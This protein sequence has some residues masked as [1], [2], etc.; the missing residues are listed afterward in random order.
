MCNGKFSGDCR[1][2]RR[3]GA[4]S[5]NV[6]NRQKVSKHFRHFSTIC[7]RPHISGPFWGALKFYNFHNLVNISDIFYCFGSGATGRERRAGGRQ[8]GFLLKVDGG[9]VSIRPKSI[10]CLAGRFGYFSFFFCSEKGKGESGSTR[11]GGS[12]FCWKSGGGGVV[13]QELRSCW[14]ARD[15]L[16]AFGPKS[17]K[18]GWK[19]GFSPH[20]GTG[21]KMAEKWE[22]SPE[23]RW[24]MA[25]WGHLCHFSAIFGGGGLN[26]FFP[27]PK[28]QPSCL[29]LTVQV[30]IITGSPVTLENVFPL[31][32]SPLP[33]PSWNLDEFI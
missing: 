26:I 33:L 6:K 16:R 32:K 31:A 1:R 3:K 12:V 22:K 11:A 20:Q 9:G 2:G 23:N 14:P 5:K 19:S 4:T 10:T 8:V 27:G 7:A 29:T 25:F 28:F 13:S 30:K 15:C 21:G 17:G 24:K 18:K